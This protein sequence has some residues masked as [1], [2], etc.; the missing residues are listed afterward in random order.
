[1]SLYCQVFDLL[2]R[3]CKIYLKHQT[4]C[5]SSLFESFLVEY[6]SFFI[7][8]VYNLKAVLTCGDLYRNMF[9][10]LYHVRESSFALKCLFMDLFSIFSA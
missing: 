3:F 8:K 10:L 5:S 1:M 7:R 4:F 9:T 6:T 2:L